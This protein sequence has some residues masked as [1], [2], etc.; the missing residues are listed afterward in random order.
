MNSNADNVFVNHNFARAQYMM[1]HDLTTDVS[2]ITRKEK[3]ANIT[4]INQESP[5]DIEDL[6]VSV[7]DSM[8]TILFANEVFLNVAKYKANEIV[9]HYHNIIRHPDMPKA[10]FRLMW[11]ALLDKHAV[12]VYV[13]NLASDGSYYWVIALAFPVE[14]G[15]LSIRLKPT[16]PLFAKVKVMYSDV[17]SYEKNLEG[18]HDREYIIKASKAYFL[19]LLAKEGFNTY[20]E[21]LKYA[22]MTEMHHRETEMTRRNVSFTYKSETGRN[23]GKIN[24]ILSEMVLLADKLEGMHD[25]LLTHSNFILHLSNTIL[26]IAINARLQSSKLDQ[27]DQSLSVISEKMGEQTQWGEEN[28]KLIIETIEDMYSTFGNLNFNVIASKVQVEMALRY[29]WEHQR[30]E[31]ENSYDHQR[32]ESFE[33]TMGFLRD[34]YNPRLKKIQKFITQV[35]VTQNKIRNSMKDIEKYL[36]ILR[37]I[38]IT[39]KVEITRMTQ[40]D[41]S[42]QETFEDLIQELETADEHLSNLR[43]VINENNSLFARYA[44]LNNQLRE[45]HT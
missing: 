13:K 14:G 38:Y 18:K 22:L 8:S 28:L 45:L 20:E 25:K 24:D 35:P 10:A 40:Q 29:L 12:A 26:S 27:S 19:E 21:F 16:S 43:S 3:K 5:F 2:N 17:L 32:A 42:F 33:K 15:Y 37:F 44:I 31:E 30:Y 9:G 1:T 23:L 36:T 7:T 11:E 41:A 4:P 34:A 39:G 6:F